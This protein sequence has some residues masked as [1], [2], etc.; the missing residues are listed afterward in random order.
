MG[1]PDQVV[2]LDD[3]A[4]AASLTEQPLRCSGAPARAF[5]GGA[6]VP[7]DH[8][9]ALLG[10]AVRGASTCAARRQGSR[11]GGTEGQGAI[12]EGVLS[13]GAGAGEG[14]EAAGATNTAFRVDA[15]TC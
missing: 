6:G 5:R 2:F 11:A 15:A 1:A 10:F 8:E 4:E 13:D 7:A 9:T 3:E 12:E 14:K